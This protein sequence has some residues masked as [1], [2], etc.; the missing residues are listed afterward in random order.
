MAKGRKGLLDSVY[1]KTG[2]GEHTIE[3]RTLYEVHRMD[4]TLPENRM[5]CTAVAS[6]TKAS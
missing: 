1:T 6:Q 2:G 4:E 5:G 3:D